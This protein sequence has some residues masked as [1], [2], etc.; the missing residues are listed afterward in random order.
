MGYRALI[1]LASDVL[2]SRQGSVELEERAE[3]LTR[4]E[5]DS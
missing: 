1:R 2:R 5:K 4:Q 3:Y